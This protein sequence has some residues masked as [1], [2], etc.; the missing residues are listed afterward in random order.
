[1]SDHNPAHEDEKETAPW[2][3]HFETESYPPNDSAELGPRFFEDI[4]DSVEP[5]THQVVLS[6]NSPTPTATPSTVENTEPTQTTSS[7]TL[8]NDDAESTPAS[9]II[10]QDDGEKSQRVTKRRRSRNSPEPDYSQ[11]ILELNK[12]RKRTGQ[13]CDRCRVR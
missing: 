3:M 11:I 5:N 12:K 6:P 9:G 13:A 1:M 8:V 4:I 2:V 7:A 10:K